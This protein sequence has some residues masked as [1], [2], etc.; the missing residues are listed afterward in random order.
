MTRFGAAALVG[1]IASLMLTAPAGA[2]TQGSFGPT[3]TGTVNIEASVPGSVRI[4]GLRDVTFSITD[5][6][7]VAT[8]EQDICVFSNSATRGYNITA[9]GDGATNAF[10]LS[11]GATG[12]VPYAVQFADTPGQ[13]TGDPLTTGTPLTGQTTT[14]ISV[15]CAVVPLST[16]SLIV[17][18]S[19]V[20][21]QT[22][23]GGVTYTGVLTLL[24]APE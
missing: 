24:V 13:T 20:D 15:V 16:A 5:P 23:T 21:L 12:T 4:S 17:S 6:S 10:T 8:D 11:E 7:V 9:T 2:S 3:S 1:G 14:A 18:M 19:P 22:M